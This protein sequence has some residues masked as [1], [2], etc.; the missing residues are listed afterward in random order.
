MSVCTFVCVILR[1]HKL[2][3][4]EHKV[5]FT[6]AFYVY[7]RIVY[8]LYYLRRIIM[9][10]E[11]FLCVVEG[12]SVYL[13][14]LKSNVW[15]AFLASDRSLICI[16]QRGLKCLCVR[17]SVLTAEIYFLFRKCVGLKKRCGNPMLK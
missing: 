7:H 13:P 12:L 3:Y 15:T 2:F 10:A 14:R 1:W 6:P 4:D 5:H 9:C 17:V 11:L 8:S 16:Q